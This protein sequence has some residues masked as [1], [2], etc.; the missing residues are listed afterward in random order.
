M[1]YISLDQGHIASG[2]PVLASDVQI[3][4]DDLDYLNALTDPGHAGVLNGSFEFDADSD[5]D[6]DGWTINLYTGGS[7]AILDGANEQT[8]GAKS[9]AFNHPGGAT[10][11]GGEATS[12]YIEIDEKVSPL[13]E[14]SVYNNSNKVCEVA[15]DYYDR[16]KTY[17]SS[18]EPWTITAL[19]STFER[20][21]IFGLPPADARFMTITIKGGKVNGTYNTA[22]R[23]IFDNIR[24]TPFPREIE[25]ADF[26]IANAGTTSGSYATLGT[27]N[28]RIPKGFTKA[29]IPAEMYVYMGEY[30][31]VTGKGFV[32]YLVNAANS[33]N[34]LTQDINHYGDMTASGLNYADIV[35]RNYG[36]L[37]VS[38]IGISGASVV[39]A[40]QGKTSS[41]TAS[42]TNV[43]GSKVAGSIKFIRK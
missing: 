8:F 3:I 2:E 22:G 14:F 13:V 35:N 26:T 11:G 12:D 27:A 39:C 21:V 7:T 19:N 38:V 43:Y 15:L 31:L 32:K 41:A 34:E 5:G 28:I 36:V 29:Y 23:A 33:S 42:T 6:P 30:G 16:A 24:C 1:A 17:I 20:I 10:N 9:F 37:E 25:G 40:L 4:K 18:E